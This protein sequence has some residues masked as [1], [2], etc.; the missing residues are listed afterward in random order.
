MVNRKF[1]LDNWNSHGRS[2][3]KGI[4]CW[5]YFN[6]WLTALA[7]TD[8]LR[9]FSPPS[10]GGENGSRPATHLSFSFLC[11]FRSRIKKYI[12]TKRNIS[13]QT[14][15]SW[16]K[17]WQDLSQ[18]RLARL[19]RFSAKYCSKAA[20]GTCSWVARPPQALRRLGAK[21]RCPLSMT[22][23]ATTKPATAPDPGIQRCGSV[24]F[25]CEAEGEVRQPRSGRNG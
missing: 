21:A 13:T 16:R 10:T 24:L 7:P 12:D 14:F 15:A 2:L 5:V 25:L 6:C 22:V 8:K 3:Q 18:R 23:Q 19:P 4:D 20:G 1:S 17:N 9:V 11:Y